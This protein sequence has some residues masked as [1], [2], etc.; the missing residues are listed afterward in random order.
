MED[1][2]NTV[3]VRSVINEKSIQGQDHSP[4]EPWTSA[5]VTN[6][7]YSLLLPCLLS[8]TI[9]KGSLSELYHLTE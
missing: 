5:E 2:L 6:D 7:A 9:A 4:S 3:G 1:I 8:R